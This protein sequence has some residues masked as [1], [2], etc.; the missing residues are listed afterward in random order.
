MMRGEQGL[1]LTPAGPSPIPS[2]AGRGVVC[3]VTPIG[4]LTQ[5]LG[6]FFSHRTHRFNR[7]FPPM[8]RAHRRPPAYRI[9]RTL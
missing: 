4:L 9:H 5:F 7:T 6:S 3:E 1:T 2:P 8:F